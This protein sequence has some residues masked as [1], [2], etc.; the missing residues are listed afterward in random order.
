MLN[1]GCP[2]E[3][4]GKGRGRSNS[5]LF[6]GATGEGDRGYELQILDSYRNE[7]YVNGQ[8]GAIY[9]QYAP[10]ANPM[11]PPGQWQSYDLEWSAPRFAMDGTLASPAILT[12]YMNGVLIQDSVTL[13]GE[14]VLT[15]KPRYS[16]HGRLPIMLQDHPDPSVP[17]SF[18]NIW[19]VETAR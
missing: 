3:S 7:T 19:V 6:L 13:H 15:G 10:L 8:A 12:A 17:V 9:K 14:T 1:G 4:K 11:R 2:K 18:R 16:P 5:G